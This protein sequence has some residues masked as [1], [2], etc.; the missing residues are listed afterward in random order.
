MGEMT[1]SGIMD[2]MGS[3]LSLG[4]ELLL[5]A[6]DPV[7]GGLLPRR[8][9]RF[10]RALAGAQGFGRW[11]PLGAW[12]ARR[13][14]HRE[15]EEAGLLAP[16]ASVRRPALADREART[17]VLGRVRR[18]VRDDDAGEPRD[19]ELLLLMG[20]SGLLSAWLNRDERRLALR[21][22]QESGAP[23]SEGVAAL[24]IVGLAATGDLFS[25]AGFGDYG[26]GEAAGLEAGGASDGGGGGQ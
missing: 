18:C 25:E 5:V 3:Q 11:T 19:R 26:G 10:R 23:I 12:R 17:A 14:A 2:G 16:D 24:G 20:W 15:L 1:N 22:L 8:R 6:T 7:R 9:R 4:A 21:R 13:R